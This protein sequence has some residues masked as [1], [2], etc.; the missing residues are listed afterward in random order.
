ME[1]ASQLKNPSALSPTRADINAAPHQRPVESL[2]AFVS[3]I[4]ELNAVEPL[5]RRLLEE[6]GQPPLTLV[7]DRAHYGPSYLAKFPKAALEVVDGSTAQAHDLVTRRPP[8]MTLVAEIPGLLHDAPC[9]FSYATLRAAQQTGAPAVLVNG[10]LYGYQ[11]P[12][13]MDRIEKLLF[14]R[15]YV[16]SFDLMLVQT[17][18][19]RDRLVEAGA[20]AGK[21]VVTGNIK[22]DAMAHTFAAPAIA[23]LRDA[24]LQRRGGPIVVAGSVSE[25]NDQRGL[26]ESFGHVLRGLPGAL[27]VLAPRHPENAE[28][29]AALRALLESSGLKW[30]LRSAHEPEEAVRGPVLV[31]DTMGELRGC[32]AAATLAYV[33]TD[34]NVLEPMAFGKPVFVSGDWNPTYPSYPVYQH[35]LKAGVL[36]AAAGTAQLGADWREMLASYPLPPALESRRLI[37]ALAEA[38]GAVE[39]CMEAIRSAGLLARV[40]QGAAA[41]AARLNPTK[42]S[43]SR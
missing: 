26:L 15:D 19:V 35:L 18:A 16:R 5:L 39:R 9:R 11:P 12:S 31:L 7:S 4:G 27:F 25:I 2:W 41:V 29:M 1:K 33:G 22:F 43:S 24:L 40:Q 6:L 34:H 30:R 28:R 37:Q 36:H 21:V 42:P 20:E 8:L 3:T 10:W 17:A 14:A 13:R 23:P 38:G 32:Y